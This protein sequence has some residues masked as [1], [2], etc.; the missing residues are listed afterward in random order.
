MDRRLEEVVEAVGGGCC[1]LQMPLGLAL[2]VR[3]RGGWAEARRPGDGGYLPPFQCIAGEGGG[4]VTVTAQQW[5]FTMKHHAHLGRGWGPCVPPTQESLGPYPTLHSPTR[6]PGLTHGK[7]GS[8]AALDQ[9]V[10]PRQH[11]L[12]HV[13][14][15]KGILLLLVGAS[16]AGRSSCTRGPS[17]L[18]GGGGCLDTPPQQPPPP[19]SL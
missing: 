19:P 8:G 3:Q 12:P 1:R 16:G 13:G 15:P 4:G 17:P 11:V 10:I 6:R 5:Q 7:R 18:G 14:P 2:A 9:H